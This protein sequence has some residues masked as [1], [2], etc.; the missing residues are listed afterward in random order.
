MTSSPV[1]YRPYIGQLTLTVACPDERVCITPEQSAY[2]F[3]TRNWTL[4]IITSDLGGGQV[5]VWFYSIHDRCS[6]YVT[7]RTCRLDEL[8]RGPEAIAAHVAWKM[9]CTGDL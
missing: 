8:M 9:G 7:P 3:G 1:F 4:G 5:R 2:W 6:T